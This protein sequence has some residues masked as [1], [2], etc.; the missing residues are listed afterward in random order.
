MAEMRAF[1]DEYGDPNLDTSI[2][3]VT[4][5]YIVAAVMVQDSETEELRSELD[6]VRSAHFQ[7]GPMKSSSIGDNV[8]R[9]LRVLQDLRGKGVHGIALVV[10]KDLIRKDSGL[11]FQR[12]FR[13]FLNRKLYDELYETFPSL[14]LTAD[15][16]GKSDF[17][18]KF[19]TFL[20]DHHHLNTLFEPSAMEW[21]SAL[22]DVFLQ[23]A[24]VICGSLGRCIDRKKLSPRADE[25]QR[26]TTPWVQL[27][28]WPWQEPSPV[29]VTETADDIRV[30]KA[31]MQRA[32]KFIEGRHATGD[33]DIRNQ[34]A[35]L[36]YL[37]FYALHIDPEAYVHAAEIIGSIQVPREMTL[38]QFQTLVVANL[39]DAGVLIAS[40]SRGYKLPSKV[41][42]VIEYLRWTNKQVEPMVA[43]ANRM[44]EAVRLATSN[45]VCLLEEDEFKYLRGPPTPSGPCSGQTS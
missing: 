42:D 34:V 39:R 36:K 24:D 32:R 44:A 30:R 40:D 8:D 29:R 14:H 1:A 37:L 5:H 25:I 13:S 12:P 6:Q 33:E 43:R 7:S 9:R 27:R 35:S 18:V 31:A 28:G 3:N 23:A 21:G 41:A 26:A 16:V 45:R 38:R 4:T 19:K 17:M 22:K 11:R 2:D 15:R 10:D 20:E